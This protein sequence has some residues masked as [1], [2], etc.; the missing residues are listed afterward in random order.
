M[1]RMLAMSAQSRW[2]QTMMGK[3][4][5]KILPMIWREARAIQTARQTSQ[6]QRM[7]LARASPKLSLTLAKAMASADARGRA[8]VFQSPK[9]KQQR[10][11]DR[12]DEIGQENQSPA[13]QHDS[14]VISDMT[15]EIMRLLPV[16]SPRR[17]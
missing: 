13:L 16:N 11:Q 17:R 15:L 2:R 8:P 3:K 5:A 4:M 1:K 12:T 10:Q 6:L 7:P 9:K 14:N